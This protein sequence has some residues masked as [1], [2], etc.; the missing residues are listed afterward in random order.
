[1]LTKRQ[2]LGV[3]LLQMVGQMAE[4]E[5][6]SDLRLW[7]QKAMIAVLGSDRIKA[8]EQ[9]G[10]L[11]NL[12]FGQQDVA[13]T[14]ETETKKTAVVTAGVTAQTAEQKAGSAAG[15][16]AQAAAGS[17][18]ILNNAYVAATGAYSALSS[19]PGG[20]P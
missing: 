5:I 18:Q 6:E 3:D 7:T 12:I 10:F 8:T 1:M 20:R 17:S 2:S 4:K 19:I 15:L 14:A 16:A 9:G 13:Q 11:W